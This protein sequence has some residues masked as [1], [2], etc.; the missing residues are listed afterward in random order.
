MFKIFSKY[1]CNHQLDRDRIIKESNDYALV[2][3]NLSYKYHKKLP[4]VLKNLTLDI[5]KNSFTTILGPNGCGKSTTA[6]AIVKLLKLKKGNIKVFDK[7]IS[8]LSFKQLAQLISYIPQSIEIPQGTRVI[9]FITFGRNP[10]LGIS[11]ILG[12]DDKAVIDLVINEMQL[13]DLK[14]KFMQELSGGQRQ[15]VVLA[16]CL[17]QDTPIILLDEPTT[18]LDIKNQYE[19]LES[20]KKLQ[21]LR[22]K[23]IIAILHDINQAIQ[24]SDE[25]FVLK[26]G[27]IYANGN[28]NEIITKTLLKDVYNIDAQIDIVDDQKIV[29]NIKVKDY[30]SNNK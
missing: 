9:D 11:G 28:P 23:T 26:D 6:K 14:E 3:D 30:L 22:Q 10:Y 2:V 15:K 16:L 20:L 27:Q 25:V 5:K 7:N 8:E 13:H 4:D 21:I 29:H 18:Y 1:F 12:K 24:Y 17:V 19:L